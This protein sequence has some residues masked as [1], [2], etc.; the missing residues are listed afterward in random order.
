MSSEKSTQEK[1]TLHPRNKNRERYDLNA[2]I[3]A[4]PELANHVK[5][6]KFGDDSVDFA[7][8]VAVSF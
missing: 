6:N 7:N 2:L 1:T 5:P 4:V 8:T 3:L